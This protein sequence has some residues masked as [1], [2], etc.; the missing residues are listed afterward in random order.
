[1]FGEGNQQ[2]STPRAEPSVSQGFTTKTPLQQ[3]GTLSFGWWVSIENERA[4]GPSPESTHANAEV[5]KFPQGGRKFL[6]IRLVFDFFTVSLVSPQ[7]IYTGVQHVNA[8]GL[9]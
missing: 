4:K 5:R 7:F 1:M 6:A 9:T 3:G 2:D 8:M